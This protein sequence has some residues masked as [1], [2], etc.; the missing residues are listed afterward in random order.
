MEKETK[1]RAMH[2]L[3]ILYERT[4]ENHPLSTGE[5]IRIMEEEYD[6]HVYRTTIASDIDQLKQFGIDINT[7]KSVQNQYFISGRLF[8]IPELKLLIDAVESSKFI[9]E[10]K[11][12]ELVNKIIKLTSSTKAD[13]L[14]R[15]L[16][17]EGRIKPGNEQ[18]YFIVDALNDAINARKKVSF[19]YFQ[20]TLP[21]NPNT[22]LKNTWLM[23]TSTTVRKDVRLYA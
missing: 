19:Q 6:L 20:F 2:L 15:H 17:T 12:K 8:D 22:Q 11:S 10:K 13:Q 16:C 21:R 1:L 4:D 9:T 14:K 18:I 23:A 7:V 3:Q 5:L